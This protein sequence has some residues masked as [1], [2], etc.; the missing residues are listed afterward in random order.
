MSIMDNSAI[1][2]IAA[3]DLTADALALLNAYRT[4]DDVICS[5]SA[6]LAQI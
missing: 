2:R 3:P 5:P 6:P 4:N 1:E